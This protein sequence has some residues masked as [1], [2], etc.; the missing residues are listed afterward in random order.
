MFG[1]YYDNRAHKHLVHTY[2][3]VPYLDSQIFD[4]ETAALKLSRKTKLRTQKAT[5]G[6]R[7]LILRNLKSFA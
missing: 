7:L 4:M 6:N 1:K 2:T 5:Q 3:R